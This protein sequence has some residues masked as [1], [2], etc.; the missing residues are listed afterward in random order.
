MCD[1]RLQAPVGKAGDRESCHWTHGHIV[2]RSQGGT[3]NPRNLITLCEAHPLHILHNLGTLTID[4]KAPHSLTFTFGFP[5]KENHI[6][7]KGIR[8]AL[9]HS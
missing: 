7:E 5:L 6:Y 8:L 3:D 4:G 2:R 1:A 9:K